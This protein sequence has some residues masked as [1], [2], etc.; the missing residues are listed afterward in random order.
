[1][2]L[3]NTS[4]VSSPS[5]RERMNWNLFPLFYFHRFQNS[6]RSRDVMRC[7]ESLRSSV[8]SVLLRCSHALQDSQ[9]KQFLGGQPKN[10]QQ[11]WSREKLQGACC[12]LC[13]GSSTCTLTTCWMK[14]LYTVG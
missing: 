3:R 10:K 4:E 5:S 1:M 8:E 14:L 6:L 2:N 11:Q 9:S 12:A 7:E 13:Q